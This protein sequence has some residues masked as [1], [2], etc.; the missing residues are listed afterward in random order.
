MD[1]EQRW[2]RHLEA[3]SLYQTLHGN[4]LVP[5]GYVIPANDDW[6]DGYVG[7]S[8][9]NWV[10]YMRTRHRQ[11]KLRED[12]VKTLDSIH[13]WEWGPLP[14]GPRP[15]HVD[16]DTEIL[17]MRRAGASLAKIGDRFGLTRQRVHQII[18]GD[19]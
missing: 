16:R 1:H 15:T 9:G 5:A 11:G 14:P 6:P 4:A 13:G 3:L 10:S 8:L 17:E 2:A 7:L 19:A 18:N 12:R